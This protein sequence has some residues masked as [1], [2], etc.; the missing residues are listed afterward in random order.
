MAYPRNIAME[1]KKN[2]SLIS[3]LDNLRKKYIDRDP[4]TNISISFPSAEV[5][6]L[7][8]SLH[9]LISESEV[10][11]FK[12]SW[13]QKPYDFCVDHYNSGLYWPIIMFVNNILSVEEFKDLDTILAPSMSSLID[14]MRLRTFESKKEELQATSEITSKTDLVF[15]DFLTQ[16]P[17]SSKVN[18]EKYKT[19][20]KEKYKS[21][22]DYVDV[23]ILQ[24]NTELIT[25]S[26]TD[27]NNKCIQLLKQPIN[28]TSVSMF[29][30][31]FNTPQRYGYDYVLNK[32]SGT[33][34][35]ILISWSRDDPNISKG[36]IGMENIFSV[37]MKVKIIYKFE[38][39]KRPSAVEAETNER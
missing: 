16:D 15:L 32:K 33:D 37:G 20:T 21:M 27:I 14:L 31:G 30:D 25:L 2:A 11:E 3:D 9:K 28:S 22:E 36:G 23:I 29:V 4:D 6:I 19:S 39:I 24:E 8:I 26:Q 17:G 7:N 5:E 38:T 1:S 12:N 35:R 10:V 34:K 18:A 13:N